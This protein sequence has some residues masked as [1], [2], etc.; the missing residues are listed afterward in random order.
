MI[1]FLRVDQFKV[2]QNLNVFPVSCE[3]THVFQD[4]RELKYLQSSEVM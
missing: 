1:D 2:V 3:H 4:Y